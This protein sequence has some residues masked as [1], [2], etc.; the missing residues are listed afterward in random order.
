MSAEPGIP[1]GQMTAIDWEGS[2]VKLGQGGGRGKSSWTQSPPPA[3]VAALHVCLF[4]L[5]I[6]VC[7]LNLSAQ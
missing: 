2:R 5:P 3:A 1:V 7:L 6:T 4:S